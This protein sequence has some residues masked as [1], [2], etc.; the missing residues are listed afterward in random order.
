MKSPR[1]DAVILVG[2]HSLLAVNYN[3]YSVSCVH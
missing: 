1:C 3:L 2:D